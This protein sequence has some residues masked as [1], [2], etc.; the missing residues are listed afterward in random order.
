MQH[1]LLPF[2]LL[3][4]SDHKWQPEF[5][6]LADHGAQHRLLRRRQ[7]GVPLQLATRGSEGAGGADAAAGGSRGAAAPAIR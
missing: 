1:P 3:G 6:E 7:P 4:A 5:P 2:P